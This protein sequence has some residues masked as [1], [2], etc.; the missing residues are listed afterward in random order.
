MP[1]SNEPQFEILPERPIQ[2]ELQ[3]VPLGYLDYDTMPYSA[4]FRESIRRQGV[5]QSIAVVAQP[6]GRYL[7]ADGRRRAGALRDVAEDRAPD[8]DWRDAVIPALVFPEGTPR[9]V[10]AAIA[11]AANMQRTSNPISELEEIE[12]LFRAGANAE[13]IAAQLH[14]P[15]NTIHARMR[16]AALPDVLR[17]AVK[18][19]RIAPSV[20]MQIVRLDPSRREIIRNLYI[21]RRV[22]E[23]E[24]DGTRATITARDVREVRQVAQS[25]QVEA[26]P[27]NIFDADEVERAVIDSPSPEQFLG[28]DPARGDR[29]FVAESPDEEGWETVVRLLERAE[30]AM[31]IA[32]DDDVEGWYQI[33][34]YLLERARTQR[35]AV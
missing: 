9:H 26:L 1:R 28:L 33:F 11:L 34:R 12:A 8:G 6:N 32:P 29:L 31:P 16:L 3:W 18:E 27:A 17:D 10:A 2:P 21:G 5:F 20:A 19:G 23:E 13:E 25:A 30:N 14:L 4:E 15:I 22:E 7:M 35:D 24:G